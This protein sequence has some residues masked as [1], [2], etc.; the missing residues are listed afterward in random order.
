MV[1]EPGTFKL[2]LGAERK[3]MPVLFNLCFF[4]GSIRYKKFRTFKKK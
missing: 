3:K 4:T 1:P 2:H